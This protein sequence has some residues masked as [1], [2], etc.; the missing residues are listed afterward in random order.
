MNLV[1]TSENSEHMPR[2]LL[3]LTQK[4]SVHMSGSCMRPIDKKKHKSTSTKT[5]VNHVFG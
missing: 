4:E 5:K 1:H 3:N 2:V